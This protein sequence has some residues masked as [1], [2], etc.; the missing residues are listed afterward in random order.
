[1]LFSFYRVSGKDLTTITKKSN[2]FLIFVIKPVLVF[3]F[4]SFIFNHI[5]DLL[6]GWAV[7]PKCS[8]INEPYFSG[9]IDNGCSWS[10]YLFGMNW[11]SQQIGTKSGAINSGAVAQVWSPS[12]V[13][14]SLIKRFFCKWVLMF[15][16]F[17]NH[18][19]ATKLFYIS[20]KSWNSLLQTR[21]FIHSWVSPI[22][23]VRAD[24]A[25]PVMSVI[26]DGSKGLHRWLCFN[27]SK[28]M[29]WWILFDYRRVF[30]II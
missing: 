24:S 30:R 23:I 20:I 22:K 13:D 1:M 18:H 29:T 27:V 4:E 12:L 7:G 8:L 19:P 26:A 3:K 17:P 9:R 21:H 11:N 25:A 28:L 6:N 16:F 15:Q 10:V 14:V 5:Q 2:S